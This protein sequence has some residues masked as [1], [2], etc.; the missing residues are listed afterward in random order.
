MM[1]QMMNIIDEAQ[2]TFWS[3]ID[4][5]S[6]AAFKILTS[7]KPPRTTIGLDQVVRAGG[8]TFAKKTVST[9]SA[10]SSRSD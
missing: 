4:F 1:T 8:Y 5:P 2:T 6:R 10:K 7:S 9:S 3:P